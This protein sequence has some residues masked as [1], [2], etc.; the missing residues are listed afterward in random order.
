M[1]SA[2]NTV[3]SRSLYR[4]LGLAILLSVSELLHGV[5]RADS[6]ARRA[7]R[8]YYVERIIELLPVCPFDL[9]GLASV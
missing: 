6:E 4:Y 5:H 1:F 8:E 9:A 2:P 3:P 7:R